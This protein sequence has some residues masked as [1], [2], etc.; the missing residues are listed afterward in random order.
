MRKKDRE[1][2]YL[3]R[4]GGE[5][6]YREAEK[7]I[8][9]EYVDKT[10]KELEEELKKREKKDYS[11]K[12][13]YNPSRFYKLKIIYN[14][15]REY[16]WILKYITPPAATALGYIVYVDRIID[17]F[18]LDVQ[19]PDT[20][21]RSLVEDL[22]SKGFN[23]IEFSDP[24]QYEIIKSFDIKFPMTFSL[25]NP[26]FANFIA[27]I[28]GLASGWYFSKRRRYTLSIV[29]SVISGL[30]LTSLTL[31]AI[32]Q[33]AAW[34]KMYNPLNPDIFS[35]M[36]RIMRELIEY[37]NNPNPIVSYRSILPLII[38]IFSNLFSTIIALWKRKRDI[39]SQYNL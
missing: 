17:N 33:L 26:S 5:E 3:R 30:L 13:E 1:E 35:S 10:I 7:I 39:I 37:I 14:K 29:V 11:E 18:Y 8:D 9:I 23:Y 21:I 22:K 27:A 38:S 4:E 34:Y 32:P 19:N 12:E 36:P 24:L 28:V 31:L 16:S 25:L 20:D 6:L 2:E 15:L